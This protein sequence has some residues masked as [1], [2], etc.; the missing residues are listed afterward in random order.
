MS[1]FAFAQDPKIAKA[2][3]RMD[4]EFTPES[5]L[6]AVDDGEMKAVELFLRGKI[7][8]NAKNSRGE[9][10]LHIAADD[11]DAKLIAMFLKAGADVNAKDKNG[12]TPLFRAAG[13]GHGGV[14]ATQPLI[15]AGA[16]LTLKYE[17]GNT[18]M[19][20]AVMS[21]FEVPLKALIAAGAD[22]NAKNEEGET[23]LRIAAMYGRK[24]TP[25][26]IQ[27]GADPN[28]KD[29]DN[30]TPLLASAT[31]GEVESVRLLLGAKADAKPADDLGG[32]PLSYAAAITPTMMTSFKKTEHD[33]TTIVE[34]LIAAGSDVNAKLK[35]SGETPLSLAARNGHA[36]AVSLLLNAKANVNAKTDPDQSTP[37]MEAAK[38]GHP[39]V[40]K[41]LLANGADAKAKDRLGKTAAKW[42]ADHPEVAALLGGTVSPSVA[43]PKVVSAEQMEIAR[44]KLFDL[45]FRDFDEDTFVSSAHTGNVEAAQAFLE[46]GLRVDS[47]SSQDRATTPLLAAASLADPTLGL[48]LIKAGANVNA[49]DQNGSTPLI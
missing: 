12:E 8:V 5:F 7:D 16:D 25:I 44:K 1:T 21:D 14:K 19:H 37:L 18:A 28:L 30:V 35:Y 27:A 40:V 26:L 46:Y 36:G 32:T 29:G 23:P 38:E 9:T 20:E 4:R 24:V 42:S 41:L 43:Q 48:F 47:K 2:L 17:Y 13:N 39:E 22:I 15:A 10:A 6:D 33:I 31:N 34:M 49:Q 45:G 3:E 11:D